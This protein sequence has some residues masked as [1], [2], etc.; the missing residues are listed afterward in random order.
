M[1]VIYNF[2]FQ[3]GISLNECFT[4]QKAMKQENIMLLFGAMEKEINDHE[5]EKHFMIVQRLL[6]PATVKIIK[7]IW[8]FKRKRKRDGKLLKHKAWICAHG[9]MQHW[10]DSYWETSYLVVNMIRVW[11]RL[12]IETNTQFRLE[13]YQFCV[14]ISSIQNKRRHLDATT[15]RI[16]TI[17]RERRE[18]RQ[19]PFSKT[20]SIVLWP[21]HASF[22]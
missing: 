12:C 16:T 19:A 2:C 13:S 7:S 18:L 3:T 9:G 17:W 5:E 1:N 20:W 11:L 14:D 8:S 21:K 4:F 6:V 15:C 22:Y 10:G